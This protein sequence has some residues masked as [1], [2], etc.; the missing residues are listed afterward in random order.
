MLSFCQLSLKRQIIV[1]MCLFSIFKGFNNS[2]SIWICLSFCE[3]SVMSDIILQKIYI[4]NKCHGVITIVSIFQYLNDVLYSVYIYMSVLSNIKLNEQE[5]VV[6]L[7]RSLIITILLPVD[8][9]FELKSLFQDRNRYFH[10]E[11]Y[12]TTL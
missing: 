11:H 10:K 2:I 9:I 5:D 7:L 3:V 1:K 12:K 6:V 8:F 4:N